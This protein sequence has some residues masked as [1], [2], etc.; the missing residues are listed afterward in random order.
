[1]AA[2][3]QKCSPRAASRWWPRPRCISAA[4]GCAAGDHASCTCCRT[5]GTGTCSSAC[6]QPI[7]WPAAAWHE[8]QAEHACRACRAAADCQCEAGGSSG[9]LCR[10]C[11]C[12]QVRHCSCHAAGPSSQPASRC[13]AASS[14]PPAS[15]PAL[16]GVQARVPPWAF[17]HCG[18]WAG[19][20]PVHSH[21]PG[22]CVLLFRL[23]VMLECNDADHCS[24]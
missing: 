11:R 9:C 23:M 21:A 17:W 8:R 7:Y 6:Q 20:V 15:T 24:S 5:A 14:T 1:M 18:G 3:V 13:T 19:Q 12:W 10:Q 4:E 16:A 22:T 2:L